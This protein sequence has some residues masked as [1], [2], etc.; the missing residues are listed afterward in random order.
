MMVRTGPVDCEADAAAERP[1]LAAPPDVRWIVER[2][3]AAGFSTWAVGGAVRDA[4]AGRA[5]GDWDLATAARPGDVRRVF[6]RTVPIGVEHG[7]V[8]VLGRDRRMYEVTTFRRDVE[9]FGRHAVVAFADRLEDDLERRDFTINA[10]AWHPQTREL[11][12]P[13]GGARD[14]RD[15]V[16]RTVGTPAERF[17]EDRLRVLRALR[18][19]GRFSLRIDDE[20]WKAIRAVAP[21]LGHLSAERI[22]EELAKVMTELPRPSVALR[23]YAES[24]T[25]A[26]WYPELE[27]CRDVPDRTGGTVW[28]HTLTVVDAV[29]GSRPRLRTVALLHDV[30]KP[31]T[32]EPRDGERFRGSGAAG[33][34]LARAALLRLKASNA[35]IDHA[36][37]LIAHQDAMPASDA[38]DVDVRRWLRGVGRAHLRDFLRLRIADARARARQGGAGEKDETEILS[39]CR[40]ARRLLREGAVL[41]VGELAIGGAELRSLGLRPGPRYGEI[42]RTL[43]DRV[44]E[45]PALN[46]RERLLG[47]VRGGLDAP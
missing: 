29:P 30:G 10:V 38:Q 43:L 4:L 32:A 1:E 41:D 12:D 47:L 28:E 26:V 35:E 40:R 22:R 36:V 46:T 18:F 15:G 6:R 45:E 42:L 5:P 44:T 13:H 25:L 19:A 23:L 27:A 16:L 2:L 33:A 17:A 34:A 14:L 3:E 20:T 9:T 39:L 7:T 8:G 24:G 37:H 31:A 11:R 21:E